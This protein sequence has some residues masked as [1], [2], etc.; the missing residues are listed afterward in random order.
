MIKTNMKTKTPA[1]LSHVDFNPP[2]PGW[3]SGLARYTR[4]RREQLGLTIE[5]AAQ[6]AGLELSQWCALESGWVPDPDDLSRI[7]A[8]A[9]TLEIFW[10]DYS[11]LVLMAACQQGPPPEKDFFDE[12]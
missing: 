10:G 4:R 11:F 9:A 1:I 12:P 6:L 7:E 8:I 3:A 5:H 2:R